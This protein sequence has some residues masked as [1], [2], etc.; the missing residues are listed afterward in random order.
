LVAKQK[1][2]LNVENIRK[3]VRENFETLI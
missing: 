2:L 1:L 3:I